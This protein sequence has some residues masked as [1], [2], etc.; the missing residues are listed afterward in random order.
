MMSVADILIPDVWLSGVK[1]NCLDYSWSPALRAH[2]RRSY[3][4]YLRVA[5]TKKPRRCRRLLTSGTT[6]NPATQTAARYWLIRMINNHIRQTMHWRPHI[7]GQRCHVRRPHF[8]F[9]IS[10]PFMELKISDMGTKL[11]N[12]VINI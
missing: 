11:N 2:K 1:W 9:R 6:Y 4:G 3:V 5:P 7:R 8:D 10:P 12:V